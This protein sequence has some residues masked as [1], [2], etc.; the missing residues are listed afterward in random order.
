[1]CAEQ[2][3]K[4]FHEDNPSRPEHTLTWQYTSHYERRTNVC[5]IMT[6]VSR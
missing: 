3:K 6:W 1:M 2:A 5:Y 4:I